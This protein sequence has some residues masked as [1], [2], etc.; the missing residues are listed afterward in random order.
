[1]HEDPH[2]QNPLL[3]STNFQWCAGKLASFGEKEKIKRAFSVQL[4]LILSHMKCE[5]VIKYFNQL[6]YEDPII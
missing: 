6:I 5:F 3:P 1:M 4:Q 2:S